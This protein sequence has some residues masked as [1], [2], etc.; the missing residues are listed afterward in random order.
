MTNLKL[1]LRASGEKQ[2]VIARKCGLSDAAL[3]QYSNGLRIPADV[4]ARLA[5]AL[6]CEP[7][8]LVGNVEDRP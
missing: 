2:G 7:A 8:E 5:E 1:K 6:N 3:S 4:L